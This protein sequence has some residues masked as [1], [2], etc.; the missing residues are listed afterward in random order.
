MRPKC[1]LFNLSLFCFFPF[2]RT[3]QRLHTCIV[4]L[5]LHCKKQTLWLKTTQE[6]EGYPSVQL[7]P[8]WKEVMANTQSRNLESGTETEAMEESFLLAC[9][10]GSL[11]SHRLQDYLPIDHTTRSGWALPRQSSIRNRTSLLIGQS[12]DGG[13]SSLLIGQ[14]DVGGVF[15]I[16]APTSQMPLACVNLTNETSQ[17]K[18]IIRLDPPRVHFHLLL[19]LYAFPPIFMWSFGIP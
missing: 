1:I 13:V 7:R 2:K 9:P 8:S 3:I 15:L 14:S 5:S 18:H 11:I 19:I 4:L 6:R 10:P 16:E 12:D 17:S